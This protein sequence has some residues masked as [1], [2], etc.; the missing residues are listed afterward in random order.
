ML[1]EI[2]VNPR[3]PIYLQIA[4]GV[5]AA[6][7]DGRLGPGDRLPAGRELAHALDVNLDTVQ[8][9]YRRLADE[10]LVTARVGRGTRIV[11]NVNRDEIDLRQHI[12]DLVTRAT[13]VGVSTR[14]LAE[15]IRSNPDTATT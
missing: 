5:R 8:R 7:V 11:D 14:Q 1:I 10:G 6:L 12:A 15:M 2:D 9:A 4:S 13:A 3:L